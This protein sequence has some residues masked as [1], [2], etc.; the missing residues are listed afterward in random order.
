MITYI[1]KSTNPISTI[2]PFPPIPANRYEFSSYKHFPTYMSMADLQAIGIIPFDG[3]IGQNQSPTYAWYSPYAVPTHQMTAMNNSAGW[4]RGHLPPLLPKISSRLTP[5][6]Q[7]QD[8]GTQS[9][10]VKK[11]EGERD[12][13]EEGVDKPKMIKKKKF[14]INNSSKQREADISYHRKKVDVQ[15]K[16]ERYRSD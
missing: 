10:V 9:I 5:T 13:E 14:Y 16:M 7:A 15:I 1:Q 4:E 11:K 6:S 2:N 3:E 8:E 12:E